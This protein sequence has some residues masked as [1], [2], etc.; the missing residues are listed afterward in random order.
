MK[1]LKDFNKDEWKYLGLW[2]QPLFSAYFW[3]HWRDGAFA[4]NFKIRTDYKEHHTII[5]NGHF[6]V[7]KKYYDKVGRQIKEKIK[8]KDKK[9]LSEIDFFVR[10]I[11][12]E[13]EE[14]IGGLDEVS[15][16]NFDSFVKNMT[17]L[18]SAWYF[19]A[20]WSYLIEDIVTE[21]ASEN[22]LTFEELYSFLPQEK[23]LVM[24]QHDN[25]IKIK[26]II[27]Q[28][29]LDAELEN[30]NLIKK[31]NNFPG[32]E[33]EINNHLDKYSFLGIGNFVGEFVS[34]KDVLADLI[35][36]DVNL[37]SS[38]RNKSKKTSKN[39]DYYVKLAHT[40]SYG[41]QYCAEYFSFLTFKSLPFLKKVCS[42]LDIKYDEFLRLSPSEIIKYFNDSKGLKSV[43]KK[44]S[45][46]F[47]YFL[48]E[49]RNVFI[50]DSK[51]VKRFINSVIYKKDD[52]SEIIIGQ[53]ASGG[54][55]QGRVKIILNPNDFKK[56]KKGNVLV[57]GMTTPEFVSL[58]QKS[59]AIITDIGGLLSHAAIVSR[60]L[61]KP[62]VIGTK[63]A[64]Q[65]L[66]DG[67]LVEVN[68]DDGVIKIIS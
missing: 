17:R 28:K 40:F 57:T 53:I 67:D 44:R 51:K 64:T 31:L 29:R 39:L 19:F 4:Q 38:K 21:I 55:A 52:N 59:V 16:D 61:K 37:V 50:I 13:G 3:M 6:L 7:N 54:K 35:N 62:C 24:K 15:L 63:I 1:S 36:V 23:T 9:F 46:D 45:G 20:I 18:N 42:K 32:L 43:I 30:G 60:E 12:R 33:K 2:S 11:C 22:G 5:A 41:R 47:I 26:K 58:M 56:F 48:D 8:K 68:A 25:L 66:K 65:A 49:N 14:V 27:R 34:L 10:E